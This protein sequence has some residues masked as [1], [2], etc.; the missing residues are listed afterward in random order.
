MTKHCLDCGLPCKDC[1]KRCVP[2][3]NKRSMNLSR[4]YQKS[5]KGIDKECKHCKL[6][7]KARAVNTEVCSLRC[8]AAYKTLIANQK[9]QQKDYEIPKPKIKLVKPDMPVRLDKNF[10]QD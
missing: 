1:A 3:G 4:G 8:L 7:F 9:W 10:N 2:C 6:P 5:E